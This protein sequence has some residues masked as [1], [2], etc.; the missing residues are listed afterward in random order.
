MVLPANVAENLRASYGHVD[1]AS[2]GMGVMSAGIINGLSGGSGGGFNGSLTVK[3]MMP[4]GKELASYILDP[5]IE[6]ARANGTPI[7]NPQRA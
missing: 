4:D 6:T 7:A 2:S 1:F 3:L 5:L